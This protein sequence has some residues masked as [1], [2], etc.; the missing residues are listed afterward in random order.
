MT[1]VNLDR[2]RRSAI[3]FKVVGRLDA[4]D[5]VALSK[6]IEDAIVGHGKPIG[7]LVDLSE[8]DGAT[9]AAR[10]EEMRFLQK[11]NDQIARLAI[12]SNDDWQ[13][14]REM[15]LIATAAM[16]AETSY[17]LSSEIDH[18]WHW[19]KRNNVENT[20]SVRVVHPGKG[21]FS[22]YTPEFTGL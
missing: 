5:V 16:Q 13:E 4:Q 21:L 2:S 3:G 11:H 7:L 22:D 12:I 6:Q 1:I 15:I 20:L 18:A 9:W 14:I 17:F 8:M 10:W 19:V